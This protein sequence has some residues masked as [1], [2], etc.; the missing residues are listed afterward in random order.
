MFEAAKTLGTIDVLRLSM[1]ANMTPSQEAFMRNCA[2]S[3][4]ADL[5]FRVW[6]ITRQ[7]GC[8][9]GEINLPKAVVLRRFIAGNDAEIDS[10]R[11]VKSFAENQRVAE[12]T[13]SSSTPSSISV[14]ASWAGRGAAAIAG[15][16]MTAQCSGTLAWLR[17]SP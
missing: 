3:M 9:R 11:S 17:S 6:F 2:L 12:E 5:F 16:T 10:V 8:E 14:T 4:A 7:R 1:H 15:S 13:S